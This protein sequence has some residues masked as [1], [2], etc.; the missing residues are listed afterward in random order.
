MYLGGFNGYVYSY[1]SMGKNTGHEASVSHGAIK[2]EQMPVFIDSL[3]KGQRMRKSTQTSAVKVFGQ[4]RRTTGSPPQ[5]SVSQ[6]LAFR[7]IPFEVRFPSP[8]KCQLLHKTSALDDIII[9]S[10]K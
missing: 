2:T 1:C 3:Q 9:L 6:C 7:C 10:F 4:A 8:A 5:H